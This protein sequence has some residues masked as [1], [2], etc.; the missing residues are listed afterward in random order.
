MAKLNFPTCLLLG[1]LISNMSCSKPGRELAAKIT[2]VGSTPCDP[3]IRAV[4]KLPPGD[5][6]EFIKWQLVRRPVQPGV[7]SALVT[8]RFGVGQPN[9]NDFKDGGAVRL[10]EGHLVPG[11]GTH[12]GTGRPVYRFSSADTSI[13][14]FLV[15]MNKDIY[16]FADNRK[17]LLVGNGGWGYVLNR[18]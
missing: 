8:F 1:M 2:Y 4:L 12:P 16:H 7:D 15:E 18:E 9:T 17:K 13:S 3:F 10:V 5:S 11:A 6:C 14:F